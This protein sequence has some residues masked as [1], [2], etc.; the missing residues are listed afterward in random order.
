MRCC[1]LTKAWHFC[2]RG[3]SDS[4]AFL[5]QATKGTSCWLDIGQRNVIQEG[6]KM[7][8]ETTESPL[9]QV[10]VRRACPRAHTNRRS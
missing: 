10:D 4:R 5:S 3:M 9:V 8:A 1:K 2:D 6:C 7:S